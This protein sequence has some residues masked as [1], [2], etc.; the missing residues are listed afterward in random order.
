MPAGSSGRAVAPAWVY[1][2]ASLG[3]INVAASP[4][5]TC[6]HSGR[7]RGEI[8]GEPS[9]GKEHFP[10]VAAAGMSADTAT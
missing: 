9:L 4:F 7:G 1:S 10:A 2:T 5:A 6:G 8:R 3:L